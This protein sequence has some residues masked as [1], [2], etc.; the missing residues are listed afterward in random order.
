MKLLHLWDVVHTTPVIPSTARCSKDLFE[1]Y[2]VEDD[3]WHLHAPDP[4][5]LSWIIRVDADSEN[6]VIT[7]TDKGCAMVAGDG[8]ILR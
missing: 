1:K 7:P 6:F 3:L 5:S 8:T 2:F 4:L